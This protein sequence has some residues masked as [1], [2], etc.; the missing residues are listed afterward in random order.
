MITAARYID[1]ARRWIGTP[2]RPAG[3]HR[4]VG[5]NC[6]GFI[7]GAARDAGLVEM[8]RIFAPYEAIARPETR[9]SLRRGLVRH[10]ERKPHEAASEGDLMLFDRGAGPTHLALVTERNARRT[11]IIHA[12]DQ[13]GRVYEFNLPWRPHCA[14]AVPGVV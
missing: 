6:L 3:A 12:C 7:A 11:V 4:G 2:Y 13:R 8:W 5:C 1:E 10:L 9:T 14:F